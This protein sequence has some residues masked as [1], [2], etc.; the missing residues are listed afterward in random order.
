MQNFPNLIYGASLQSS[1]PHS[2]LDQHSLLS[3][4]YAKRKE[5]QHS[6]LNP[7][8]HSI[9]CILHRKPSSLLTA[10]NDVLIFALITPRTDLYD[11]TGCT[12][13]QLLLHTLLP[14]LHPEFL[15]CKSHV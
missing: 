12:T 11:S 7:V 5:K 9:L 15:G 4:L 3:S 10:F 8:P 14:I 2:F 1:K 6:S 13:L